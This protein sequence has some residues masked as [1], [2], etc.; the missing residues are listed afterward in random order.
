MPLRLAHSRQPIR[1]SSSPNDLPPSLSES[2][3]LQ[4]RS[5]PDTLQLLAMHRPIVLKVIQDFAERSAA[6]IRAKLAKEKSA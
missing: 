2:N 6:P 5:L 1:I 4:L 3:H